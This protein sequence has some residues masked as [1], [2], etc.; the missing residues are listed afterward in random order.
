MTLLICTITLKIKQR[1][2]F[3]QLRRI[4]QRLLLKY[5]IFHISNNFPNILILPTN[6]NNKR[7]EQTSSCKY[8]FF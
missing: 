3:H 1:R 2:R 4:L 5:N 8:L 6:F 7:L